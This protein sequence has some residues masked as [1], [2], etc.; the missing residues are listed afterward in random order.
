MSFC[1]SRRIS[2][3]GREPFALRS[4]SRRATARSPASFRERLGGRTRLDDLGAVTRRFTAEHH[5]IE[6]RVR[7]ETIRTVHRHARRLAHRHES[8]HHGFRAGRA[9]SERFAVNVAG[10]PPML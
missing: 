9:S 10:I 8:R 2:A 3:V 5:Q 4:L 1:I 7:A 6:Q